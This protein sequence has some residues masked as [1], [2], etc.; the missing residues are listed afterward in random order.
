MPS[1]RRTALAIT[2]SSRAGTAVDPELPEVAQP[3]GDRLADVGTVL[4]DAAA[5]RKNVDPAEH[6]R[7]P[8]DRLR[9]VVR[10]VGERERLVRPPS[11]FRPDSSLRTRSSS[12]TV[13]PLRTRWRR[14][15]G[16]TEPERV[17][18]GGPSS[19]V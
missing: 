14:A 2:S 12:S 18:I 11:A 8:G 5:E 6:R 9:Q 7:H 1:I 16:S 19:G 3:P 10:E 4:A 15:P 17:P 13:W